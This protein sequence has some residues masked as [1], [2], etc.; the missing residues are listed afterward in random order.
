MKSI[1]RIKVLFVLWFALLAYCAIFSANVYMNMILLFCGFCFL[2][3]AAS[4]ISE[5]MTEKEEKYFN[6]NI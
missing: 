4:Y 2:I 6:N 3:A 5:R 1:N